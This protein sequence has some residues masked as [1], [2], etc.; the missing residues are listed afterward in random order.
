MEYSADVNKTVTE[1]KKSLLMREKKMSFSFSL[2]F[3]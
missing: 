3:P 1:K 2:R